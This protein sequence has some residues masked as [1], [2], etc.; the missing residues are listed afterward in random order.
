V[1]DEKGLNAQ[2]G[3]AGGQGQAVKEESG[4]A[5]NLDL[6]TPLSTYLTSS[7]GNLSSLA[8]D[9]MFSFWSANESIL[10]ARNTHRE[11]IA[12]MRIAD[13]LGEIWEARHLLALLYL[14]DYNKEFFEDPNNV[15]KFADIVSRLAKLY[16]DFTTGK[17]TNYGDFIFE[18][19]MIRIELE[20]L[21]IE[22]IGI[23]T[24]AKQ[25]NK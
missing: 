2:T 8:L 5:P 3:G 7:F 14:N 20:N 1:Q 6:C 15:K 21:L 9:I 23:K 19:S 4:V 25:G 13:S 16:N 12:S 22:A 17:V 24:P 18:L 10:G 11:R